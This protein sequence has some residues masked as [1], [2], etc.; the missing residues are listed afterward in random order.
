[1]A[2]SLPLVI[3][4][5]QIY[6][7]K[8]PD[9]KCLKKIAP[10]F[11]I[12]LFFVPIAIL[13]QDIPQSHISILKRMFVVLINVP[14]YLLKTFLPFNL[15][16]IY[17][18][19]IMTPAQ[20]ALTILFYIFSASCLFFYLRK[21]KGFFFFAKIAFPLCFLFSLAPVSGF[22]PLGAIDYADR[23]SYIPSVFIISFAGV[24]IDK[25]FAE[26][27]G[28]EKTILLS[29]LSIYIAVLSGITFFYSETWRSYRAVLESAVLHDPP[30]YMALG[31]LAD[32]E[33]FS[34]GRNRVPEL[35]R[36]IRE[37]ERGWES[38][39]GVKKILMKADFLE[40]IL[41]REMGKK[42]EAQKKAR[43]LKETL[44]S[45]LFPDKKEFSEVSKIVQETLSEQ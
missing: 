11:A 34:G 26:G 15:S 22:V 1:M 32:M 27:R 5:T 18:R 21:S 39:G 25:F 16:P 20:A 40:L 45:A 31:A 35:C 2:V 38:E 37:R 23:Y 7:T 9:S 4:F 14:W 42:A 24:F 41:Y 6:I 33:F 12:A 8:K 28:K 36:R 44:D 29:F 19:I 13:F 10:F 43:Q 17:P 30:A 3:L